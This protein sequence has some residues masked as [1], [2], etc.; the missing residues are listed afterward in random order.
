MTGLILAGGSGARMG[1]DKAAMPFEGEPMASRVAR[2]LAS[3]CEELLVASG[4]GTRLGWLGL[5]Q[6]AD[7]VPGAGPLGGL[8]VGLEASTTELTAAV[9]VDMPHVNPPLLSLMAGLW[10][11][12]DA[13][14]P[15]SA[16]GPEP[17]HAIYAGARAA[18]RLRRTLEAG[19]RSLRQ[20][21]ELLSV[22]TVPRD[23][24]RAVDPEGRF[25]QNLNRPEDLARPDPVEGQHPRP[26]PAGRPRPRPDLQPGSSP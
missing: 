16:D 13:V 25:A 17:L 9:G 21:L 2:A 8:V 6:V 7:A 23:V 18:P 26:G 3:V 11:G 22:R 4:D 1:R 24:W 20:A 12:E 19:T 15:V 14:V 5:R 10:R